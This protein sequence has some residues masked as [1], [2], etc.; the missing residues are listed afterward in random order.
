[1]KPK[2]KVKK[3]LSSKEI[4]VGAGD[5][6]DA[7]KKAQNEFIISELEAFCIKNKKHKMG[8]DHDTIRYCISKIK[9][10]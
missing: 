5:F 8:W 2:I 3:V 10:L 6:L 9:K 4:V 1:M 7:L